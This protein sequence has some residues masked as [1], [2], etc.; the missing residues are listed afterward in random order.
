MYHQLYKVAAS[1]RFQNLNE[2]EFLKIFSELVAKLL[3]ESLT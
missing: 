3:T 1:L 2:S